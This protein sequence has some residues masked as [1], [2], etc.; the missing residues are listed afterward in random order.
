[1]IQLYIF[2]RVIMCIF[3]LLCLLMYAKFDL[4]FASYR[5]S[6]K[7]WNFELYVYQSEFQSWEILTSTHV[8][9]YLK[10]LKQ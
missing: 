7:S 8:H 4:I 2:V 6:I 3:Q 10:R 9:K 1:M 5:C